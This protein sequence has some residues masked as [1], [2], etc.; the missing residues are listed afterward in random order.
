MLIVLQLAFGVFGP[1]PISDIL[2]GVIAYI[3]KVLAAIVIIV[4]A[5]AIAAAV[6]DLI[7]ATLGGLEYGRVLATVAGAAMSRWGCSPR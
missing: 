6:K 3:P 7:Q 5:A 4:I 1:N 2:D